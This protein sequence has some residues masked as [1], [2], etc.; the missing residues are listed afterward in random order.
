M[1][2]HI[3]HKTLQPLIRSHMSVGEEYSF[4]QVW[5]IYQKILNLDDF[6]KYIKMSEKV[7]RQSMKNWS[8]SYTSW[9]ITNRRGVKVFYTLREPDMCCLVS[10]RARII[11]RALSRFNEKIKRYA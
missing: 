1:E 6:L 5:T 3:D 9:I 2:E 4:D 10:E 11:N 7:L 8:S